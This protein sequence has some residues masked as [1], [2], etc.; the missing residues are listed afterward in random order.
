MKKEYT[1]ENELDKE[2]AERKKTER[3]RVSMVASTSNEKEAVERT[4]FIIL[5]LFYK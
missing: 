1:N 2:D 3:N 4:A 5:I